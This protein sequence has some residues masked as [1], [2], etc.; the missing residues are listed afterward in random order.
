MKYRVTFPYACFVSVDVEASNEEEAKELA[1]DDSSIGSYCG[2]GGTNKLIGVYGN[3]V[4]IE[5]GEV[6][7]DDCDFQIQIEE[8]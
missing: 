6:P 7:L 4:S 3:N 8:I 5:A 1:F 2:N